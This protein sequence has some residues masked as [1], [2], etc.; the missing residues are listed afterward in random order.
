MLLG[1]PG[2]T[3]NTQELYDVVASMIAGPDRLKHLNKYEIDSAGDAV[4]ALE[5]LPTVLAYLAERRHVEAVEQACDHAIPGVI[6]CLRAENA[7]LRD[8]VTMLS[9]KADVTG[10]EFCRNSRERGC[11]PC[12]ACA[13]CVNEYRDRAESAERERD[14]AL[15]KL[16]P[17]EEWYNQHSCSHDCSRICHHLGCT[18]AIIRE[19]SGKRVCA[20]GHEGRWVERADL[21]AAMEQAR[22]RE[23]KLTDE[24]AGVSS[25]LA[26]RGETIASL[27]KANA[28]YEKAAL[29]MVRRLGA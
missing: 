11:N 7:Q 22:V 23:K 12:G 21:E 3:V 26:H 4:A 14:A 24:L 27:Q 2:V 29:E 25:A 16:K 28:A 1:H 20:T 15:E 17:F 5:L 19:D 18:S 8:E 9:A 13:V 10:G 6:D